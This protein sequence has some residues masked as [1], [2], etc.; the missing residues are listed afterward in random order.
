MSPATLTDLLDRVKACEGA[1]QELNEEAATAL[2]WTRRK[3][4][5]LGLNGRTPGRWLWVSPEPPWDARR[6]PN[7]IGPRRRAA[8]V[9]ALLTALLAQSKEVQNG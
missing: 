5:G 8:T 7:L 4:T 2:G 3:V 1:D 9:A 6:L